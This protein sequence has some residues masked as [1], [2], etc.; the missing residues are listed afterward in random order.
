ML[1]IHL[2]VTWPVDNKK[3]Y[4]NYDKRII[5]M[6]SYRCRRQCVVEVRVIYICGSDSGHA[7]IHWS[8]LGQN[9]TVYNMEMNYAWTI[10]QWAVTQLAYASVHPKSVGWGE[11][12]RAK[13]KLTVDMKMEAQHFL[14]FKQNC[15]TKFQTIRKQLWVV[16]K[17]F[18]QYSVIIYR[19]HIRSR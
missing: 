6:R 13:H 19:S 17:W 10:W 4:L 18:W 5:M 1:E 12:Q 3:I 8:H 2:N 9:G 16:F 14:S 7:D 15:E 11:Q